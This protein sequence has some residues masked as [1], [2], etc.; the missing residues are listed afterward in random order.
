MKKCRPAGRQGGTGFVSISL[1]DLRRAPF[2]P[3]RQ[4]AQ[5]VLGKVC[6][7]RLRGHGL[8]RE[9]AIGNQARHQD[10]ANFADN[11]P[12][13]L[14]EKPLVIQGVYVVRQT[15]QERMN[16]LP[17]LP[18]SILEGKILHIQAETDV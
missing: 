10:E 14:L 18:R 9:I 7:N 6:K 3:F 11:G 15:L 8:S 12:V 1:P 13:F 5:I 4:I 16:L 17:F 2:D